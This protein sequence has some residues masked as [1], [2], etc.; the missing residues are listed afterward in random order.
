MLKTLGSVQFTR[1]VLLDKGLHSAISHRCDSD[2]PALGQLSVMQ[3]TKPLLQQQ[4][5]PAP[6]KLIRPREVRHHLRRKLR[7]AFLAH[8]K[9]FQQLRNPVLEPPQHHPPSR[10]HADLIL[11]A[12]RHDPDLVREIPPH[13]QRPHQPLPSLPAAPSQRRTHA[14]PTTA[15]T[16]TAPPNLL[17][18]LRLALI[19]VPQIQRPP[20]PLQ[21]QHIHLRAGRDVA[22]RGPE[23]DVRRMQQHDAEPAVLGFLPLLLMLPP[24]PAFPP[25]LLL[26]LLLPPVVL[27]LL[28][29]NAALVFG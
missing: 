1:K 5:V 25:F 28:D 13:R 22:Q 7:A 17:T 12:L 23:V 15:T 19:P 3:P 11:P 16:T 6:P 24:L 29:D 8:A 4:T 18:P 26:L 21:K 20:Q 2:S 9:R 14:N 27:P 10:R